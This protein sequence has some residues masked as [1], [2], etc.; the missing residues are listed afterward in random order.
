MRGDLWD[1]PHLKEGV[2]SSL[3]EEPFGV[4]KVRGGCRLYR[5][6]YSS[7]FEGNC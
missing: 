2:S 1:W 3:K 4:I 7:L 6:Y 5:V